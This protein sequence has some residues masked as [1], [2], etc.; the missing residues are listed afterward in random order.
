[1][2]TA[3]QPPPQSRYRTFH[4]PKKFSCALLQAVF[5]TPDLGSLPSVT[6]NQFTF[7]RISVFIVKLRAQIYIQIT[8]VFFSNKPLIL[9][10]LSL[11]PLKLLFLFRLRIWDLCPLHLFCTFSDQFHFFVSF[12]HVIPELFIFPQSDC[13]NIDSSV[14][15]Y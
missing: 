2:Y 11:F 13:H 8:N 9:F 10:I 5:F 4:P 15:L 3:G 1:M 12:F 7:S 14:A 6:V